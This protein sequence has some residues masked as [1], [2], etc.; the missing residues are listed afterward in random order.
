MIISSNCIRQEWKWY[1]CNGE[2]KSDGLEFSIKYPKDWTTSNGIRP[3]I[4][5]T[6][7]FE[8]KRGN[9]KMTIYIN[10]FDYK[11]SELDI[12]NIYDKS[13]VLEALNAFEVLEFNDNVTMDGLRAVY[14][15][16]YSKEKIYD[17]EV[18]AVVKSNI[19]VWDIYLLQIG[20]SIMSNDQNYNTMYTMYEEYNNIFKE[21]MYS[22]AIHS[23]WK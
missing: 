19:L 5:Q 9:I 3:H 21:V 7:D 15:T 12:T 4:L 14:A 2:G 20:F 10:T 16:I 18:H 6:F 22:L 13:N 23:Q 11:P 17:E 1:E 8:E